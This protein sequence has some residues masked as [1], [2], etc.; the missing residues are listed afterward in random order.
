M[1]G[2]F[3]AEEIIDKIGGSVDMRFGS[4]AMAQT[5]APVSTDTRELSGGEIF[6]ALIGE[7]HDAHDH[8]EEAAAKGAAVLVVSDGSRVKPGMTV[9]TP[10]MTVGTPGGPVVIVVED[11]LRAYQDLAAY[12]RSKVD[13][14]V[15]AVTGSVG[16]TTLKDMI[17]CIVK[18]DFHTVATQGN[19]NNQIGLPKTI[20]GMSAD[21]EALVLEMGMGGPGE[22]GRLAQIAGPD[23]AAITNIGISH[24]ECFDSDDGIMLEKL[25]AA[26]Q[27]GEGGRL[28]IDR[29]N[30]WP[31]TQRARADSKARGYRLIE[32]APKGRTGGDADYY[33]GPVR[34]DTESAAASFE[35]ESGEMAE[36]FLVPVPGDYAAATSALAC[37]AVARLGIDLAGAAAALKNLARTPHRLQTIRKDGILVIDDT[38]NASPDS[39]RSGLIFLK[40]AEASRRIA[41]LADMNEL[42]PDSEALHR[43]LGSE[44]GA[45]LSAGRIDSLV[46]FGEKARAIAAGAGEIAGTDHIRVCPD[47][48]EMIAAL[49]AGK[50]PGDAYLVKGSHSMHMEI[51]AN[52]LIEQ[53]TEA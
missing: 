52:A 38:Y 18:D 11:T 19:F 34:F 36:R 8:L 47:R 3:T 29:E 53:G 28:V 40:S 13:P 51:V 10:G 6:F 26:S 16:K 41:V 46:C 37:A 2:L 4:P 5:P 33:Y 9:G 50:T 25:A 49:L 43:S 23:V 15:I 31:L 27:M 42:G 30:H 17:A 22:I 35:I 39:C 32:V 14:Y 45:D 44:I 48:E 21:T 1:A 12:Y 24:R 20:L 7:N